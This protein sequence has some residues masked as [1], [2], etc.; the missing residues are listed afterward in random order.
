MAVLLG[1]T[2]RWRSAAGYLVLIRRSIVSRSHAGLTGR[3]AAEHAVMARRTGC[4]HAVAAAGEP[5]AVQ[6]A[7]W[8]SVREHARSR[9]AEGAW[10]GDGGR[11][12]AVRRACGRARGRAG[13]QT[14]LLGEW[15]DGRS[16]GDGVLL[17]MAFSMAMGLSLRDADLGV[18]FGLQFLIDAGQP[19]TASTDPLRA[20]VAVLRDE[21]E[22]LCGVKCEGT[23]GLQM[24]RTM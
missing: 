3:C 24:R 15:E 9:T 7:L 1:Y 19:V 5:T 11:L 18:I 23:V 8:C 22:H 20:S 12:T 16:A 10:K 17:V 13:S 6:I 14:G 2:L 4:G 21:P